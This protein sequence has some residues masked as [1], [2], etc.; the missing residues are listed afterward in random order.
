MSSWRGF[1]WVLCSS[2][3]VWFSPWCV[4]DFVVGVASCL[5]VVILLLFRIPESLPPD[6]DT[7]VSSVFVVVPVI[8]VC[9]H[10]IINGEPNSGK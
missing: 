9:L 4:F 3:G 5:G 2:H 8:P 7:C 6:P 10:V 1:S